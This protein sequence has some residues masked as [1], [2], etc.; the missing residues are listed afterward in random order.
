MPKRRSVLLRNRVYEIESPR[1]PSHGQVGTLIA[2][3]RQTNLGI[4][5]LNPQVPSWETKVP[6]NL[7]DLARSRSLVVKEQA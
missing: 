2:I 3:D 5:E 4:L 6:V 7:D 1:H